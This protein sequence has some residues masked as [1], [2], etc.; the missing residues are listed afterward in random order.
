[1]FFFPRTYSEIPL[2]MKTCEEERGVIQRRDVGKKR[3]GLKRIREV[4]KRVVK[5]NGEARS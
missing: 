5:K 4:V 3:V 2:F 1:M